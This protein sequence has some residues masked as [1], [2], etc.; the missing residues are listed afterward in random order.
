MGGERETSLI[1]SGSFE[2]LFVIQGSKGDK[3]TIHAVR[4][5]IQEGGAVD[6]GK[7]C[8]QKMKRE[9]KRLLGDG[10]RLTKRGELEHILFITCRSRAKLM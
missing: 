5:A 1:S 9:P 8:D 7:S 3:Q 10:C 2:L 4:A 6:L